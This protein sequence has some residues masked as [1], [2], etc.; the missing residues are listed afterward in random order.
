MTVFGLPA[1]AADLGRCAGDGPRAHRGRRR[2]ALVEG[3]PRAISTRAGARRRGRRRARERPAGSGL[4][5]RPVSLPAVNDDPTPPRRPRPSGPVQYKGEDLTSERGPGLG[6]FRIQLVVLAVFVVLT[7]LS[8]V[9]DWP[10]GGQCGAPVRRDPAA[11]D[12]RPDDHLPAA[13]GRRRSARSP[14]T[15][16]EQHADGRGAG[17]LGGAS[18]RCV[19]RGRDAAEPADPAIATRGRA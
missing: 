18:G 10:A 7:P 2:V 11:A 5:R 3:A 15:V 6:C 17:R 1:D 4:S 19:R 13:P 14:P 16:G 8:V 12:H 9:W